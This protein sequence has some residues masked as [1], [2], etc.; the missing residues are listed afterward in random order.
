MRKRRFSHILAWELWAVIVACLS[1]GN[2]IG[3]LFLAI[4][5][6]T[7]FTASSGMYVKYGTLTGS[8]LPLAPTL[9]RKYDAAR[10]LETFAAT[11]RT[12]TDL[13][14]LTQHLIRAAE[15]TM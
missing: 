13:R 3:W 7:G 1:P 6:G 10:T 5:I 15:E 9:E 14:S 8:H 4:G 11:L 2:T 12:E